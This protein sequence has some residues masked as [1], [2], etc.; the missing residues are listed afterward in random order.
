MTGYLAD[1]SVL[2]RVGRS[3]VVRDRVAS[4][5]RS[6]A[7]WTCEVVTLEIGYS[8][9]NHDEWD[10]VVRAQH[11]LRQAAVT[12]VVARRAVEVQGLLARRGH[13]RVALPDLLIA[14]AAEAA[15]VAVLHYDSDYATISATTGQPVEWV[16][17]AGSID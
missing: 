12:E 4:L 14:A 7:L 15:D 5:R 13:H 6:G 11:E 2:N 16:A 10:A 3:P 17:R 9:R 8:A 1:T